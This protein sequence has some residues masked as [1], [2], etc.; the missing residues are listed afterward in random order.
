MCRLPNFFLVGAPK[1]GTSSLYHYLDQHPQI[2]MSPVKEPNFFAA[3][4]REENFEAARQR[5]LIRDQRCLREFLAGSMREQRFGGIVQHNKDYLR[6]FANAK[7]ELALGE[8]SVCY[9]WSPTA[10]ARIAERIPDAKILIMLRDPAERA[11]SQYLH[12]LGNGAI[13]WTFREHIERNLRHRTPQFCIHYPF[14]EF[15]LY[16]G[17]IARYLDRFGRNVWVGLYEDFKA[18]PSRVFEEICRFLGVDPGFAPDMTRRHMETQVPRMAA[19][20]WLRRSGF[21]EAA[22]H[23]TPTS[24]RPH[25]RRMLV[26]KPGA[27][28]MDPADRQYL[29]EF[30]RQDIRQLEGLIGREF[31]GWVR[32]EPLAAMRAER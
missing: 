20:A 2:Y 4:I 30:Y 12:G 26:R 13:R 10:A 32:T 29:V 11:F 1:A 28:R 3:E 23:L 31:D 8:A 22:A 7:E 9:L 17:Q 5:A 18:R 14:L 21:W 24:L 6:L 27:A 16:A 19:V 25:I 15:G